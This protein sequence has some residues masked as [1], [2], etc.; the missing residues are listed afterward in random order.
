MTGP[1]LWRQRFDACAADCDLAT[2]EGRA[3][4]DLRLRA[5]IAR[6]YPRA[7]RRHYE[8]FFRRARAQLFLALDHPTARLPDEGSW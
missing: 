4:F 5:V 7:L 8:A 1:P 2:P 6:T 3:R